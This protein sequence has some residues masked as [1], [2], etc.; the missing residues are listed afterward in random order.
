VLSKILRH[1]IYSGCYVYGLTKNEARGH[2]TGCSGVRRVPV[3][4]L[5]W[6]VLIP[7]HVPA[8][9]T[10][11]RYL[12][13]QARLRANRSGP[14]AAGVPR[15]GPSL[16]AGLVYCA[17]CC[18]RMQVAYRSATDPVHYYLCFWQA[19]QQ[20]GPR[21]Q[22]LAGRPL[23]ALVTALVLEVLQPVAV[24]LSLAAVADLQAERR[25]LHALWQQRLRRARY[26]SEYAERQ[27]QS[28]DPQHRLVACELE[29]RWEQA[30]L[31]QRQL[32]EQYDHFIKEQPLELTD[33]D[34][35][36]LMQLA[37]DL[38]GLW[39]A[40]TTT[41]QDRQEIVRLLVERVVVA[42]RE[43]TEMV[44]VTIQWTGGFQTR[45]EMRRPVLR[46]DHM[47][48]YE[49][50]R[51]RVVEL[52]QQGRTAT[53]IAATLNEENHHPLPKKGQFNKQMIYDFLRRI[54]LSGPRRGTRV[55]AG[56]LEPEEWGASALAR[57]L[58]M[59]V[60][61]L[62]RWCSRGW[63]RHRKLPGPRGCLVLWA[64]D[65]EVDRLKKLRAFRP[66]SYPPVYPA[67]LTT[68][69][70]RPRADSTS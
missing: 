34:R 31:E 43:Q 45:H 7:D 47:S 8:Y 64:D 44:D 42:T 15:K 58:G 69:G 36:N 50:L 60:D 52:R 39:Q 56:E 46:Y 33:A 70:A 38:R 4:P 5:Q 12:A 40:T 67:E 9:I 29:R 6:E 65:A 18:R 3:A 57:V 68:P 22:R 54:G 51:G 37:A 25:R 13:N 62:S 49:S 63:V 19:N 61:T 23:D 21:C 1:P 32:G 11:E 16:L 35:R 2:G 24:E 27:Y 20:A 55:P 53:E 48:N 66:G 59:P 28:V 26:E 17:R 41:I 14:G 10:W 30:L